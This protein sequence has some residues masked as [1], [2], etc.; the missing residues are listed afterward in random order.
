MWRWSAVVAAGNCATVTGPSGSLMVRSSAVMPRGPT[1]ATLQPVG[2]EGAVVVVTIVGTG[3]SVVVVVV[4]WGRV[5]DTG[6]SVG[7]A[8]F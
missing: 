3:G 4:P 7:A 8:A 5:V 1:D 6:G 2:G